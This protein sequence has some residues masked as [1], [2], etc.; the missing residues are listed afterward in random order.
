M[1]SLPRRDKSRNEGEKT[2]VEEVI[3][4][5]DLIG[6]RERAL[7]KVAQEPRRARACIICAYTREHGGSQGARKRRGKQ[8]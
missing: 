3:D 4:E 7:R 1:W 6:H 2:H 5:L 8:R